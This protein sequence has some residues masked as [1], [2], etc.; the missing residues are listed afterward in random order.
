MRRSTTRWSVAGVLLLLLSTF[1]VASTVGSAYAAPPSAGVDLG[2]DVLVFD[3]SM[4]T[5]QIQVAADAVYEQ[6]KDAEMGTGRKALLFKPG[7]YGS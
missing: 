3:P 6:Q 5:A 2:P 1:A 4:S 7:V